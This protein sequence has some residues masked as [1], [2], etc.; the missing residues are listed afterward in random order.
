MIYSIVTPVYNR[1]DLAILSIKSSLFFLKSYKLNGEIIIIDDASTDNLK[2][3]L[4]D[5]FSNEFEE[6]IIKYYLLDENIGPT[7]A[8][9]YGASVSKGDYLI[10]M[11][12]DDEFFLDDKTING[13]I[14]QYLTNNYSLI[15]FR[16]ISK[17]SQSKIGGEGEYT[18]NYKQYVKYGTPGECLPVIKKHIFLENNYIE[19][20]RGFEHIA[21]ARIIKKVGFAYISNSILRIYNDI[22]NPIRVTSKKNVMNRSKILYQGYF[23]YLKENW[24]SMSFYSIPILTRIIYYLL[25][26]VLKKINEVF[27]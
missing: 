26:R 7:G 18:I 21:Y 19:F 12:S 27:D 25:L 16:C 8:K 24:L 5:I 2:N 1:K 3:T 11:D 4:F 17:N 22:E 10:F 9:N 20:L 23:I 15:F 6:S 13:T 14:F